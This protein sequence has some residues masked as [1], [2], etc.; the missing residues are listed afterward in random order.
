MP[1]IKNRSKQYLFKNKLNS[2]LKSKGELLKESFL[3]MIFGLLLLLINYFIPKKMELFNSFKNNILEIFSNIL[4]ILFFSLEILI[5]LLVSFTILLSLFLIVGSV[6]RII[7]VV[8]RKS[9]KIS[10]R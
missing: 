1:I 4:E 8:L 6:N 2:R 10:I 7:K 5:V 9:R 3:M